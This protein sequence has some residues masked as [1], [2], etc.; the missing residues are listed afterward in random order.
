MGHVLSLDDDHVTVG[1]LEQVGTSAADAVLYQPV[2]TH[3][4]ASLAYPS[5]DKWTPSM[6]YHRAQSSTQEW[7]PAHFLLVQVG[8]SAADA[9]LYQ[10]VRNHVSASLA[11]PSV[12]KW[13]PS[14]EYHRAQSSTQEWRPAH[15]LLVQVG[16]SAADAVLYQPVRNHVS[17]SLAY[18]S[19]DKWTPSMEYHRAQSSTQEWRPAHFLLVQVGTSAADA[20]LY[21]PVRNH[22]SASLAYP[23]VDK[24]TPSMEYHR[25]QSS[26]QEW[27]PAHFLRRASLGPDLRAVRRARGRSDRQ[28]ESECGVAAMVSSPASGAHHSV[29]SVR[30]TRHTVCICILLCWS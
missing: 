18:P 26:T 27:R 6:E 10:P 9:V 3:V 28:R 4:S 19:V 15:F 30:R 8:T 22:V 24:W 7:R 17:A 25:A 16:T 12:D 21:Q 29:G 5:V 2:R 13:T 11:Y 23:S 14:M 20:V 1:Q